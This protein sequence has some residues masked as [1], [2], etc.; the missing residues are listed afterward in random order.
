M[1]LTLLL[2]AALPTQ[3]DYGRADAW[4]CRPGRRDACSADQSA[5]VIAP[6]GTRRVE[7]YAP[8]R[9][10]KADCFYVYPTVSLDAGG[11]S[12]MIAGPEERAVVASQFARFASRCRPF[13]PV[14][15]QVTLTALRGIMAGK[16]VPIDRELAFADVRTAFRHYLAT[17]GDTRPF[18]LVGHSQGASL[19][20]RLVQEEIDGKPLQR[21]MLSAMMMGT[22]LAVPAGRDV[23]GDFRSVPLCRSGRQTGCAIAYVTFREDAPPPANTRFGKVEGAGLTAACVNPASPGGNRFSAL[24]AYLP[25]AGQPSQPAGPWTRGGP[26]VTT[27]FVKVPGLLTGRCVSSPTGSYLSVSIN[28][29]PADPRT[30]TIT[31]DVVVAGKRLPDWGLHLIDVAVAQGDLVGLVASQ[32]AAWRPARAATAIAR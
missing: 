15:R 14:Y 19:I 7:R 27:P 17:D 26:T 2:A 29:V 12:D 6:D 22:N 5:T 23:G 25:T 28:A 4:L 20:K 24:D 9:A 11:N 13:A 32:S 18:V 1:L 30:D 10:P 31:G 8:A 16:A 21:R 3:P